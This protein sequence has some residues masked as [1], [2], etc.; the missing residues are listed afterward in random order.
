MF[1]ESNNTTR[2]IYLNIF[3]QIHEKE[4]IPEAWLHGQILRLYKAKG[5]KGKCSNERGITLASNVGKLY[6]RIINERIKKVVHITE[7][8][9][10]GKRAVPQ[11]TT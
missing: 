8:Q 11:L 10:G 1:I 4:E 2:K 7:A 3:N 9:A 6:E 5:I